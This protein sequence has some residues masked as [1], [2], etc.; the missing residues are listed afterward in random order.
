[1]I[2]YKGEICH[3]SSHNQEKVLCGDKI[4]AEI[5]GDEREPALERVEG[6]M[7][8]RTLNGERA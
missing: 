5:L 1:M 2:E 4:Q 8:E 7:Y 6:R 3:D